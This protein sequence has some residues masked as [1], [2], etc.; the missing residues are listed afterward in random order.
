MRI[1]FH[2]SSLYA[3]GY[4][5]MSARGLSLFLQA[6]LNNFSMLLH[7][8]SSIEQ[9]LHVSPQEAYPHPSTTKYGLIWNWVD[10]GRRRLV[11]HQGSLIGATNLML[12]N[13]K[14]TL[15]AILLTTGDISTA[16]NHT[17]EA[18][19]TMT[20]IMTQLFDCFE[21]SQNT[22]TNQYVSSF[23]IWLMTGFFSF[24]LRH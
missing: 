11:G 2:G 3:S 21:T 7:N 24:Y 22:A 8:S 16:T 4:L 19:N 10:I 1:P 15:G 6:F 5:R 12:A 18:A 20:S 17:M 23:F 9:M 13:E 14:R